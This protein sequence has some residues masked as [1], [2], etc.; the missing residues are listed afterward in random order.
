MT[1][2]KNESIWAEQ[3]AF[4]V[5]KHGYTEAKRLCAKYRDMNSWNTA[6]YA[7]HNAVCKQI[8]LFATVG[9]ID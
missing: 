2:D 1:R 7:F 3:A 9:K 5:R 8:E 6:S 4:M